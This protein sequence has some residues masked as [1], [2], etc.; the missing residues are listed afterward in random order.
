MTLVIGFILGIAL[1]SLIDC[2]AYR[3]LTT[4]TFFG[5]SYCD[6]CK[7]QLAWYDLIPIISYLSLKGKCR[8]CHKSLPIEFLLVEIL[9]GLLVSLLF[10]IYLPANFPSLNPQTLTFTLL[11]LGFKSFIICI[12]IIVLLTDLKKGLIPNR[13]TY[14]SIIITFVY[15]LTISISKIVL[16]YFSMTNDPL[17]KLLLPPHSDYFYRHAL[18][19][20]QPLGEN[21]LA[22]FLLGL[23]FF[24]LIVFTRGRGMG[25]GDF[26]LSIFLGLAFGLYN[27]L[28]LL[29]LAFFTGSIVGILLLIFGQK[30]IGQ[31]IPF[32]PF[33]TLG[34]LITLF[35]GEKL[36]SW[37]LNLKLV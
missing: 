17:G 9:T 2:L 27:S 3:S 28:A 16:L 4:E 5:R 23:F 14:P 32:G 36:L 8:Y 25:G 37:Y 21:L 35:W 31:T 10:F 7:K 12:L 15:L 18:I 26:K 22:S 1:G 11:D 34:S 33:L 13:I 29:M 6:K 30:K 20:L 19:L 24:L